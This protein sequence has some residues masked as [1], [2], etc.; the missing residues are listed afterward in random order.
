MK[1]CTISTM[2]S[3]MMKVGEHVG[4]VKTKKRMN[5]RIEVMS[6]GEDGEG[7]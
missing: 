1:V 5:G 7:D 3:V 2:I 4:C 6:T